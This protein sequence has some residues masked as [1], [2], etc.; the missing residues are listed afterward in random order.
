MNRV[1]GILGYFYQ[2][3]DAE[4]NCE[5]K[6]QS[7]NQLFQSSDDLLFGDQNILRL[8]QIYSPCWNILKDIERAAV[9]ENGSRVKHAQIQEYSL[10]KNSG[11]NAHEDTLRLVPG[12]DRCL[13]QDLKL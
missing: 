8:I 10:D 5:D 9:S 13:I 3:V 11:Q 7:K 6:Y 12:D 2:E 4:L 1:Q